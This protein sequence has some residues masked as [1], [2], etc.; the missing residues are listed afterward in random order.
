MKTIFTLLS[1][2]LI[3]GVNAQQPWS[4]RQCIEHAIEHNVEIK[5]QNVTRNQQ[6]VDVHTAKL[7]RLP[8]LS[9]SV[10]Q[11]FAFGRSTSPEDN[12][13]IN[14]NTA[15]TSF[16]LN[17]SVS[18][19]NGMQITNNI[20]LA[21]LNLQAAIEDLNKAKEDISIQVTSSFLQVLFNQELCKVGA[22]QVELS[23]EQYN[24]FVKMQ[25]VGKASLAEM[26]EA[27]SRLAQDELAS[28]Q[29][30]NNRELALLDLSQLLEL[31]SPEGFVILT[32]DA[33]LEFMSPTPP[34]EIYN[35]VV[36]S[37]PGVLAAHYRLE[38]TSKSVRIAQS[39]L[40]PQLS[41]GAGISTGYHS[42]S[43][44]D[45]PS[46]GSQ[47]S[48]NFSK[49]L[50]FNLSIPIFN[51]L[52][53]R[54]QVKS[55]RL[56]QLDQSLQLE[57][58]KK[59]LYKEIQQAYYNAIAA[60]AKYRSSGTAVEAAQESFRLMR[61]KYE[62]GKAT[63]VQYNE[64]KTILFKSISDQIQ[65]KFDHLFRMKILDFYKGVPLELK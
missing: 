36:L 20:A 33:E 59:G 6:N 43:G 54:D 58:V 46:F 29:A 26:Y 64:S 38:G 3:S 8:N 18:L 25:E 31:P 13:Y 49:S 21:K 7:S 32:P 44:F 30:E 42:I 22:Q 15:N 24:R 17:T 62:Q 12:T 48:N 61:E 16:D 51:R 9:G 39:A 57:N 56:K 65:A 27:K 5:Q 28:V 40:Y 4:L 14:Q 60:Q 63:A 50:G 45:D 1:L 11:S 52:E 34:E 47:W 10:G 23:R 41:F 37:R 35:I 55:A 19:F 2:L 53:T